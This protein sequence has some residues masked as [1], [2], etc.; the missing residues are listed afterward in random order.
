MGPDRTVDH[1]LFAG[2]DQNLLAEVFSAAEELSPRKGETIYTQRRFRRC[3]GVL[4][5]GRVQVD[6]GAL[7]MSVLRAGDL[8][9]AA[10]LFTDGADYPATLTA[11][12]DCRILL[13]PQEGIRRLI[14][15]DGG[16]A[17]RYVT[18]LSGR[19]RFLTGRLGALSA[20]SA[21]GK[22]ARYLLAGCGED[23]ELTLSAVQ[24]C[25]RIG[26]GRATLYRSFEELERAGAIARDRKTIRVTDREKLK[27]LAGRSPA[28]EKE[29]NDRYEV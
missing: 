3:L 2:V 7:A 20:V 22:L 27:A 4:L 21:E 11:L 26:V 19:I 29:R 6:K 9:G 5:E 10:A 17:E 28:T 8:F 15:E 25:R 13:I 14:R 24:L 23:G 18:Y 12:T 1:P 16:F